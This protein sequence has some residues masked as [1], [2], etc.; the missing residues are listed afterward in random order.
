MINEMM[1]VDLIDIN[2]TSLSMITIDIRSSKAA[3]KLSNSAAVERGEHGRPSSASI[4]STATAVPPE[5]A[6]CPRLADARRSSAEP[7][8]AALQPALAAWRAPATV[9]PLV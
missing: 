5:L 9:G 2:F 4:H 3:R 1:L 6:V 8:S 7:P